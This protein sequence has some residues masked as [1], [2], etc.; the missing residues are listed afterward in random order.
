MRL[1][2]LQLSHQPIGLDHYF[3][4]RVSVV[5]FVKKQP[6]VAIYSNHII[7]YDRVIVAT[8]SGPTNYDDSW[9]APVGPNNTMMHVD[10]Y[11]EWSHKI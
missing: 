5:Y 4:A 7:I 10:C 1:G 8:A 9:L 2:Q 3:N 11:R 6:A